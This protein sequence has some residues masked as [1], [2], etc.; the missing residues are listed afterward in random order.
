MAL[1]GIF[2]AP[3]SLRPR[4]ELLAHL[5]GLLGGLQRRSARFGEQENQLHFPGS[6]LRN[7]QSVA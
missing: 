1:S 3:S 5:N 2:N 7:V 6:E 4:T